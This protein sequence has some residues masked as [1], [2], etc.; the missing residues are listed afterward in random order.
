M[1]YIKR[2]RRADFDRFPR[3]VPRTAGEL[4]F[5][6][7]TIVNSYLRYKELNYQTLNDIIGALDGC[8]LEFYRRQV[9]VYEDKKILENGDVY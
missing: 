8:K 9:A 7:T 6:L 5:C 2:E 1:P 3:E 4:N